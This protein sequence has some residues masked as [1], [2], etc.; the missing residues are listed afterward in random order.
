MKGHPLKATIAAAS[1]RFPPLLH[2]KEKHYGCNPS[3]H[4]FG[5]L[6]SAEQPQCTAVIVTTT[7]TIEYRGNTNLNHPMHW[8]TI[9]IH[10]SKVIMYSNML[11][12]NHKNDYKCTYPTSI[13]GNGTAMRVGLSREHRCCSDS[14]LHISW[15][16]LLW[17][18]STLAVSIMLETAVTFKFY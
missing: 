10:V 13:E 6:R 9:K 11:V 16:D 3:L 5:V 4:C 18:S 15:P 17:E 8:N 12:F 7:A 1:L 14:E 2:H